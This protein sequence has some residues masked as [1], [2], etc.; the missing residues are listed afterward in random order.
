MKFGDFAFFVAVVCFVVL[1]IGVI[2]KHT[3]NK[4]DEY[5]KELESNRQYSRE[6][7]RLQK[8]TIEVQQKQINHLQNRILNNHDTIN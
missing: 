6:V 3:D 2:E 4:K 5:I 1:M 8:Q 7:I